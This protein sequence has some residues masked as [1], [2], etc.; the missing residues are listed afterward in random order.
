LLAG[1]CFLL[2]DFISCTHYAREYHVRVLKI[3]NYLLK[4]YSMMEAEGTIQ[5]TAW[6]L[7]EIA[8]ST[9]LSLAFLRN[10]VRRNALPVRRFGRRV[11]VLEEDLR[12]YLASGSQKTNTS[13]GASLPAE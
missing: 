6:G 3:N 8:E 5:R 11:L 9:G 4:G 1:F 10:E 7:A 13:S 2:L 12:R